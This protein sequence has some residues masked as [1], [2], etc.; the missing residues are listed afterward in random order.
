MTTI[1]VF[2]SLKYYIEYM[3]IILYKKCYRR[4]YLGNQVYDTAILMVV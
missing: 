1:Q 4:Y 2:E 3:T